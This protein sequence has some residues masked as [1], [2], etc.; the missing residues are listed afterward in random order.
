MDAFV[1]CWDGREYRLPEMLEWEFS[2]GVGEPCDGFV[3]TCLWEP[4]AEKLMA[5]CPFYT[6][7]KIPAGT[8]PG[9][10]ADVSTVTVKPERPDRPALWAKAYIGIP[11]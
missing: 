2:Y 5:D 1:T 7:H 9:Q 11:P 8:Y 10:D 6:V 3:L 4:G